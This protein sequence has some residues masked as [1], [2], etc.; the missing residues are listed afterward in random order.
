MEIIYS[1]GGNPTFYNIAVVSH[2]FLYGAQ[3]P[4]TIYG[5][6]HFADQ[7]WKNPDRERYLMELARH[8][9][10]IASVLDWER[11]E[12][13]DEVLGWA[14]DAAQFAQEIMIIPK[15]VG[16]ISRIPSKIA[17]RLVRLGYSVSTGYSGTPVPIWEFARWP[18]HLLGGSPHQQVKLMRYFN[19]VSVDGNMIMKMATGKTRSGIV[20]VWQPNK[21][22]YKKGHF[23]PLDEYR[24][25]EFGLP[26]VE[27]DAPQ[28]AFEY[29]CKNVM[30]MWQAIL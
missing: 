12:Q 10:R 21:R 19:T 16:G 28:Q 23:V 3:L 17:N 30:E 29:S 13:L 2:K 7:D 11:P 22:K 20:S 25:V 26:P 14:E 4:D 1:G 24:Q 5:P 18:V 15:V 6:L 27:W 8:R 9:P